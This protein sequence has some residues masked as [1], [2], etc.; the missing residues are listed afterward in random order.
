MVGILGHM[1]QDY[2]MVLRRGVGLG[3]EGLGMVGDLQD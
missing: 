2:R 3:R 1:Q